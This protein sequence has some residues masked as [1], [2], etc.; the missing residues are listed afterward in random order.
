MTLAI[1]RKAGNRPYPPR[2]TEFT[3]PFWT[4]LSNGRFMLS[5]CEDCA[6]RSFPP[7]KICP[8]CWSKRIGWTEH[9]GRGVIY[10]HAQV[11][12]APAYFQNELPF[13]VCVVDLRNGPRIAT[14]LIEATDGGLFGAAVG[15]VTLQYDDGALF[16]AR[17]S[18]SGGLS[19]DA[20][21]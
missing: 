2:L 17:P 9:D 4:E 10:S 12:A 21:P 11:H 6:H 16:A 3:M 15:L 20:D 1:I 14:R 5:C 18:R 13:R 7:K 8:I 19:S